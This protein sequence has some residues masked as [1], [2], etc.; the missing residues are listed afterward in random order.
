MKEAASLWQISERRVRSLCADGRI[1]GAARHGDWAWSIPVTTARPIDGRSL[2][3]MKNTGFRIGAQDYSPAD[4]LKGR[5][6]SRA[7]REIAVTQSIALGLS[8]DEVHIPDDD[9][10]AILEGRIVPGYDLKQHIIVCNMATALQEMPE[11][12]N[13]YNVRLTNSAILC[14]ADNENKGIFKGLD[15]QHQ[16]AT[17]ML[18]Y[19]KDWSALH[20]IARATFLFGE[21]LRI[22]P[23]RQ[24]N[25]ATAVCALQQVLNLALYPLA[26]IP[27]DRDG[28]MKAA[29]AGTGLR[30]NYQ[31]L[32]RMICDAVA[33][34]LD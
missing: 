25:G 24:A 1:E 11:S 2:R 34:K 7:E 31:E 19:Q 22:K 26:E 33:R 29:L 21:L 9:I 27:S 3:F 4:A 20:P 6:L 15:Q 13:D 23:F 8:L 30:G 12:V 32:V 28:E 17:L 5:K 18:Q 16:F 14:S 10:N